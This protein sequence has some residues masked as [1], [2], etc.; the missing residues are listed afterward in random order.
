MTSHKITCGNACKKFSNLVKTN[1]NSLSDVPKIIRD[2]K[3]QI[4]G[5]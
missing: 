1:S 5:R 2:L 4:N 3:I